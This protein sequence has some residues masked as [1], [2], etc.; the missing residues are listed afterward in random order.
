MS[1]TLT[2]EQIQEKLNVLFPDGSIT[3][4]EYSGTYKGVDSLFLDKDFG[5]FTT[6]VQTLLEGRVSHT[7]R[8]KVEKAQISIDNAYGTGIYKVLSVDPEKGRHGVNSVILDI[9]ENKTFN[10]RIKSMLDKKGKQIARKQ[11][12]MKRG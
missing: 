1:K 4:I 3:I 8:I 11:N 10:A 2:K 12:K 7:E 6:S 9:K 5:V